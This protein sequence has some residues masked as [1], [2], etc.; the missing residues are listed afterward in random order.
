[1]AEENVQ[2]GVNTLK[3][4]ISDKDNTVETF[5]NPADLG[6]VVPAVIAA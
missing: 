6:D 4:F 3:G 2:A 5:Q 1:L